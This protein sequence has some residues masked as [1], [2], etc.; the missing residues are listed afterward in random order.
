VY[1]GTGLSYTVKFYIEQV[2]IW[3]NSE[4]CQNRNAGQNA[5]KSILVVRGGKGSSKENNTI[6]LSLT[7]TQGGPR[8]ILTASD[9]RLEEHHARLPKG[10]IDNAGADLY[11]MAT[12]RKLMPA[13]ES[14]LCNLSHFFFCHEAL[15]A[16][17]LE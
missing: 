7:V 12:P 1:F 10:F 8:H 17:T 6:N 5:R 4:R 9:Q 11:K 14:R 16:K 3:I 15:D 2:C 13:T